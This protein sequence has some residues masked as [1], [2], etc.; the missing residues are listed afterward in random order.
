MAERV[1]VDKMTKVGF[2]EVEVLD[3]RP[4]SLDAAALYPL[5]T[6]ELIALMRELI[7]PEQQAEVAVAVTMAARKPRR[8]ATQVAEHRSDAR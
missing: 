5:F 4:F 8:S 6:P 2:G 7:P 3:R 1:F